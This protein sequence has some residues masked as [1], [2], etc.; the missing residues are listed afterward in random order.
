MSPRSDG[1]DSLD[2]ALAFL[3]RAH[4]FRLGDL[5]T[6][7]RHPRTG[8]L[9]EIAR[10]DLAGAIRLLR[11]LEIEAV[12]VVLRHVDEIDRMSDEIRATL[13]GGGRVFLC[14]CGATGR[15][16]LSLETLWREKIATGAEGAQAGGYRPDQVISFIAGGDYALVRSIENFEDHPEF[17][18]RQLRELGFSA[19]D[20]LIACTEGGETPFVIGATEEAET[21]A[22]RAPFF[23]YCNPPDILQRTVERS[24][25]VIENPRIHSISLAVGP[26]ALAG[27]TRLQASTALM[28]AVGA[29]LFEPLTLRRPGH[30]IEDLASCLETARLEG[31]APLIERE[32][33]LY[34][35]GDFC[36]HRARDHAITVLTDTTERSPTFSLVPFENILDP[37]APLSWTYLHVPG[38]RDAE[39]AWRRLLGGRAPRA[40]AWPQYAESYGHQKLMGF[41]FSDSIEQRRELVATP[42]RQIVYSVTAERDRLVFEIDGQRAE[43]PRPP[44]LLIEHLLVKCALN[45]S[46]TLVMGRLGRFSGNLMLYVKASNNKLVD[47]S[48]RFTQ[49]LLEEAGIFDFAYNDICR[50]LFETLKTLAP[51]EGAVPK[52]FERL[53]ATHI[54][55][56]KRDNK[57]TRE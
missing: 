36:L 26:M 5:P 49:A 35:E 22:S 50:A 32:T 38:A 40:L 34:G 7:S 51:G 15:L 17:G 28:L 42:R 4:D 11:E 6:E 24:R 31:L 8:A 44:S 41:D 48:I 30:T 12:K 20:L 33:N 25:R 16:S 45:I 21:L 23:L 39:E 53:R 54:G 37:V 56:N 27:S 57:Q 43:L 19:K 55:I 14:G 46:S 10:S 47:R 1:H 18:A 52:T 2:R 3:A 29:A 9:A 13:A